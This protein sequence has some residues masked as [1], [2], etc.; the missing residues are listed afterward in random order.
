MM[1]VYRVTKCAYINDLS[2][3]GASVYPGRWNSKGVYILYT[4][5]TPSLALLENRVHMPSMPNEDYCL[6]KLSI[7]GDKIQ[8]I[9][10]SDLPS[11]WFTFP[12]PHKLK[13]I[14]DTFV[15]DNIYLG[16]IIP[17][18]VLPEEQN[19]LINPRHADFAFSKVV[20]VRN[21]PIDGRLFS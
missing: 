20:S 19:L 12:A 13:L 17:S 18:A 14:G 10:L 21:I 3:W 9:E 7:P 15:K 5:L 1:D 11:D 6:A 4:S 8:D 2:G 16:L